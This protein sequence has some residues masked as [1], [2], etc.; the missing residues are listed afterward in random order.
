MIGVLFTL[1][2]LLGQASSVAATAS[3]TNPGP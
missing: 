3:S 1:V 2:L